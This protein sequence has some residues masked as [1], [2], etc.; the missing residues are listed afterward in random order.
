MLGVA[1]AEA[2]IALILSGL[3]LIVWRMARWLSIPCL[4]DSVE[5]VESL[6]SGA[7][8]ALDINNDPTLSN[9][10][11]RIKM[12][13]KHKYLPKGTLVKLKFDHSIGV[14]TG[15]ISEVPTTRSIQYTGSSIM[16][17]TRTFNKPASSKLSDN[18][19]F[20]YFLDKSFKQVTLLTSTTNHRRLR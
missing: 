18:I 10:W 19:F 16:K 13:K 2:I 8:I 9:R 11:R 14:I 4:Q 12:S 6:R 5:E 20:I 17:I 7:T 1:V 15:I 3:S